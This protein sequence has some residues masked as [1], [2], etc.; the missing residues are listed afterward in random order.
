MAVWL[1]SGQPVFSSSDCEEMFDVLNAR[2]D[3][4][5]TESDRAAFI[6]GCQA[7]DGTTQGRP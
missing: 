3:S 5:T 7:F 2:P 4:G 1:T 6:A